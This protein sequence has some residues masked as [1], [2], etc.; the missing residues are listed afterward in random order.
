MVTFLII[1]LIHPKPENLTDLINLV[2]KKELEV[3]LAFDGDADR[4]GNCF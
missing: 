3:G 4:R 1:T 2:K